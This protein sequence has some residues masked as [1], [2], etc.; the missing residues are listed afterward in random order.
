MDSEPAAAV[1]SKKHVCFEQSPE[2]RIPLPYPEQTPCVPAVSPTVRPMTYV[3]LPCH[4]LARKVDRCEAAWRREFK[5]SL[6]EAGPPNHLD[7]NV[8]SD[9]LD[10][11]KELYLF[12]QVP[13]EQHGH[14]LQHL[15]RERAK[16]AALHHRARCAQERKVSRAL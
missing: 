15:L 16:Y 6:R 14:I 4:I 9:L 13:A 11:T 8:D 5:L 2:S 1:E 10:V 3:V 7:D 12:P